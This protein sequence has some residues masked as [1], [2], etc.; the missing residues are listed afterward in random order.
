VRGRQTV[1]GGLR[2]AD[3][4]VDLA[5]FCLEETLEGF[6]VDDVLA[7]RAKGVEDFHLKSWRFPEAS[8]I[9]LLFINNILIFFI[10]KKN[11][12]RRRC[13]W[14]ERREKEQGRKTNR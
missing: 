7:S 1:D 11:N 12:N 2:V 4:G 3:D 6:T 9:G 10:I 5:H 13:H 8:V 14:K